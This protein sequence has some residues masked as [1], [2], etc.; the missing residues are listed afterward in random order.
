MIKI[1]E[2]GSLNWQFPNQFKSREEKIEWIRAIF[3]CESYVG[4]KN[5][6]L[7]SVSE[8][9]INSIKEL[10]EEFGV[11]SKIYRYKRKKKKQNTN[12]LLFISRKE[13]IRKYLKLIGFNHPKKLKKLKILAGVPEWLMGRSRIS[14]RKPLSARTSRFKS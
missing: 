12:Y 2:F 9:G 11:N 3:D 14:K 6:Q 1:A 4:P 10:L 13:N 7:Q 8:K 5:I